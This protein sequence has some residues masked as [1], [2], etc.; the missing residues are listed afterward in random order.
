VVVA[1]GTATAL[2]VLYHLSMI[3]PGVLDAMERSHGASLPASYAELEEGIAGLARAGDAEWLG[4]LSRYKG[5]VG[6]ARLAEWLRDQ[7]HV[8]ELA[9]APNQEG[10]DALVDG[11]PVQLK[12]GLES[13]EI[14]RHLEEHPDI[15]VVTVSE[16]AGVFGDSVLAADV[17]GRE[18]EAMTASTLEG[19]VGL[20]EVGLAFPGFTFFFSGVRNGA[21]VLK[22]RKTV[23]EGLQDT[24][25]DTVLIGS[26]G[27]M[28]AKVGA[29]LGAW[30]GPFVAAPMAIVGGYAGAV[31]GG[32]VARWQRTKKFREARDELACAERHAVRAY[33]AALNAKAR[34]LEDLATRV[35]PSLWRRL[36][37]RDGVWIRQRIA[38]RHAERAGAIRAHHAS[39][40]EGTIDDVL[41][42]IRE[43][44][45]VYSS[46]LK[47]ALTR[48]EVA[49][50][51]VDQLGDAV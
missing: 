4:M 38:E 21:G 15:P 13:G 26:G 5:Y 29:A 14:A 19:M 9:D 50:R 22:G 39:L 30:G 31:V 12:A 11:E 23:T 46:A 51:R 3:Y 43:G 25:T 33:R 6:E 45:A 48:L 40:R 32:K 1:A 18:I 2:D 28:G 37:G 42:S 7:G 34:A 36:I 10:W 17:S 24:A 20:D 49:R 44:F 41:S 8:V 47:R 16:H 35:R 27:L